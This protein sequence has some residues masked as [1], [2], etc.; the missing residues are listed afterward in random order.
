MQTRDK[1]LRWLSAS[2]FTIA[3]CAAFW[4]VP[5]PVAPEF[6][7]PLAGAR[8]VLPAQFSGEFLPS[9]GELAASA[10]LTQLPDGRL[11]AAWITGAQDGAD[12][13]GIWFSLM[14]NGNWQQPQPI[15]NRESTAGG[16]FAHV[17]S[18]DHPVLYSEGSWL[19]LW[20]VSTSLGG[21]G[22]RTIQ[23]SVST[24]AGASWLKPTQLPISPL[25][26]GKPALGANP[27]P[28]S[29]GGIM[30]ALFSPNA[31][32]AS[33]WLRLSATG[34]VLDKIHAPALS[35]PANPNTP[36]AQLHLM[37]GRLLLVGNPPGSNAR[38][39]AWISSDHGK[40]WTSGRNLESAPDGGAEFTQPALLQGRDGLIHLAYTWRRQ[41]IKHL[42][43]SEAWLDEDNGKGKP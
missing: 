21:L 43:F 39:Q 6:L 25:G 40:S 26:A 12:D 14:S 5:S 3:L 24:D 1:G 37:S 34:Q 33:N 15:A 9:I 27:M 41:R 35:T 13:A 17:R 11:G 31:A 28:L 16:S 36:S 38:L 29:D 10:S 8:A 42:A 7:P 4:G 23:H 20:Y 2:L 22:G 32:Q 18:I 19:H 30:L